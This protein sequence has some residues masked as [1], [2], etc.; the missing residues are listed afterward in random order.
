MNSILNKLLE[1]NRIYLQALHACL[2]LDFNK[3]MFV[4]EIEGKYTINSI[5]KAAADAGYTP[6]K[7]IFVIL[8]RT[9][10]FSY[11]SRFTAITI[12]KNGN[13]DN[14]FSTCG[15]NNNKFVSFD[16]FY[17]KKDFENVRKVATH[18]IVICQNR[19]L[20]RIP[21]RKNIDN[22]QRHT[23]VN[24]QINT[25]YG[26]TQKCITS[27]S[28]QTTKTNGL[29]YQ[30]DTKKYNTLD[31]NDLIDKSGYL[32]IYRRENLMRRAAALRAEKA[33]NAYKSIDNTEKINALKNAIL[34][35]KKEIISLL[36]AATNSD[37]ISKV[38]KKLKYFHGLEG[39]MHDFERL[40]NSEKNKE[41]KSIE[42]FNEYYLSIENKLKA[43]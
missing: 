19:D 10:N 30:L 33:E 34:E 6:N 15:Y 18:T 41:Y 36:N 40:E 12:D 31:I 22:T 16:R 13:T 24:I 21:D 3:D 14:D 17:T 1:T 27:L 39:V 20:L 37:D 4:M 2:G 5:L 28:L 32:L 7:N 35:K 43:I 11:Y 25:P 23:N 38:N 26:S 42:S 8:S 9:T 29:R